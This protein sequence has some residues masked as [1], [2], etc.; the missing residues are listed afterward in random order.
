MS[1]TVTRRDVR[2]PYSGSGAVVRALVAATPESPAGAVIRNLH[3]SRR[4]CGVPGHLDHATGPAWMDM[5][6]RAEYFPI[7][8]RSVS[9]VRRPGRTDPAA[10]IQQQGAATASPG[11]DHGF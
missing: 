3:A 7:R 8:S 1:R 6:R 2:P 4:T 11:K 10:Q 5:P 9:L